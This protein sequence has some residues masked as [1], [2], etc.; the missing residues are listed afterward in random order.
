MENTKYKMSKVGPEFIY[1]F[2]VCVCVCVNVLKNENS[3]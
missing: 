3:C 2:F 1:L